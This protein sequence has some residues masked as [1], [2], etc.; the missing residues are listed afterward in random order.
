MAKTSKQRNKQASLAPAQ[1]SRIEFKGHNLGGPADGVSGN[2]EGNGNDSAGVPGSSMDISGDVSSANQTPAK[3]SSR[4]SARSQAKSSSSRRGKV[5][6]N[7][8]KE[9]DSVQS[10]LNQG[11]NDDADGGADDSMFGGDDAASGGVLPPF[12]DDSGN[13]V[14]LTRLDLQS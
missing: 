8:H 2:P 1:E 4:K 10:L 3:S 13:M 5:S 9:F 14:D 11:G 7:L 12:K 6:R